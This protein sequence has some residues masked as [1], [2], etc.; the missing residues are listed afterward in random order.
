MKKKIGSKAAAGIG[1]QWHPNFRD[2]D[3]LPDIKAVR[4]SF[5]TSALF[6]T[7]AVM[8]AM[9]VGFREYTTMQLEENIHELDTENF[10]YQ[11]KNNMALNKNKQFRD[12]STRLNQVDA[13][14]SGQ[15]IG[16]DFILAIGSKVT[17]EM[18]LTS[19]EYRKDMVVINGE[20]VGERASVTESVDAYISALKESEADQG[21]FSEYD[22]LSLQGS[23]DGSSMQFRIV[24]SNP[25]EDNKG[26][27]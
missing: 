11:A 9:Y 16:S 24:I 15:L 22:L 21:L 7:L 2:F 10:A 14:V 19:L 23:A 26:K 5:F 1:E 4:T 20:I 8:A 13:F 3:S 12:F 17:E 27:K 25:A 18:A 6:M